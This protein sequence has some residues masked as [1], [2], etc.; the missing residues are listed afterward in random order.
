VDDLE[1]Y[2]DRLLRHVRSDTDDDACLLV[3]RFA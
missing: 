3:V 2:A 1:E